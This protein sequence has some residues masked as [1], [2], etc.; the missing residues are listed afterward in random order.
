MDESIRF[1][2]LLSDGLYKALE[3]ATENDQVNIQLTQ[4]IVEEFKTQS[5]L[6][7]LA[8]AVVDKISR[9]HHD[10]F[11]NS[12][13]PSRVSKREDMTLMIRNFNFPLRAA[14]ISSP[15]SD[16]V[17]RF[18]SYTST[19]SN[20]STPTP[21]KQS[22]ASGFPTNPEILV[23]QDN[24]PGSGTVTNTN[25][26]ADTSSTDSSERIPQGFDDSLK[27]EPYVDFSEY[28]NVM[29]SDP[30]LHDDSFF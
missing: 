2:V 29:A 9:M 21:T 24:F 28:F 14:S 23:S 12:T 15:N 18:P 22:P 16:R 26:T 1:L 8:Q 7:G 13:S 11:M 4:M 27:V 17:G 20:N 30:Q 19:S 3:E 6:N 10:Y 25:Y 5:T